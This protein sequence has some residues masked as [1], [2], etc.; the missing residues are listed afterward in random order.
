MPTVQEAIEFMKT[1]FKKD[2][3]SNFKKKVVVQ[4]NIGKTDP[5]QIHVIID[6]GE[7]QIVEG[8]TDKSNAQVTFD[9]A[10]SFY[11]VTVGELSG[12]K[13]YLTGKIKISG[14]QVLLQQFNKVFQD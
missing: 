5:E 4:Y 9:S 6:N 8:A 12:M 7:L 10:E 11:K 14:S 13:A 1:Q 2:V 3:A